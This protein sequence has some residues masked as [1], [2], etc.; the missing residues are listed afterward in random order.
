MNEL[1]LPKKSEHS[2]SLKP[3]MDTV[4]VALY[5]NISI[6]TVINRIKAGKLRAYKEGKNWKIKRE[7]VDD[8]QNDLI[9]NFLKK[10]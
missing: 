5:L 7:W 2:S 3:T 10:G 9:S 1:S 4:D 6:Y 8:Y